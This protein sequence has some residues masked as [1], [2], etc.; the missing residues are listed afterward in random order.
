MDIK[1]FIYSLIYIYIDLYSLS[2]IGL[3]L[4]AFEEVKDQRYLTL[5][6]KCTLAYKRYSTLKARCTAEVV[7]LPTLLYG[8]ESWKTKATDINRI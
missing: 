6:T 8:S 3:E 4:L 7:A 5:F 2:Y 1:L